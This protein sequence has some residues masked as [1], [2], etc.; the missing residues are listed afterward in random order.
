M[1][2]KK[3]ISE[4]GKEAMASVAA[5]PKKKTR[6]K[7]SSKKA[8]KKTTRRKV[9]SK[10]ELSGLRHAS[11]IVKRAKLLIAEADSGPRSSL[12]ARRR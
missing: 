9:C 12:A 2:R 5:T 3:T 6:K 7:A 8:S 11:S 4:L 10:D 1:A